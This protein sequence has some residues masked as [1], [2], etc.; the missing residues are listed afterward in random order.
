MISDPPINI[1]DPCKANDH[2]LCYY[3]E[4]RRSWSPCDCDDTYHAGKPR[5]TG[6]MQ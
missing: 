3:W 4:R 1:C 2:R 6:G 5:P